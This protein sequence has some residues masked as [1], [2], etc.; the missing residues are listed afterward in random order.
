MTI[1]DMLFG[2]SL[3]GL[4]MMALG[5]FVYFPLIFIGMFIIVVS[6]YFMLKC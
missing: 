1:I 4:V 3:F 2:T 5:A 6:I